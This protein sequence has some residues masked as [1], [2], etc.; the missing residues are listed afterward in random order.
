MNELN[1]MIESAN[2]RV[3]T[4]SEQYMD[5]AIPNFAKSALGIK[6]VMALF[7]SGVIGKVR[8]RANENRKAQGIDLA[9][10]YDVQ[11]GINDLASEEF[12]TTQEERVTF[13]GRLKTLLNATPEGKEAPFKFVSEIDAMA[14]ILE[15]QKWATNHPQNDKISKSA[16]AEFIDGIDL[17]QEPKA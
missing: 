4:L 13:A 16:M 17:P 14:V 15:C 2:P 5:D 8:R 6:T 3:V 11:L 9:T 12:Q 7:L 1:C 10:G